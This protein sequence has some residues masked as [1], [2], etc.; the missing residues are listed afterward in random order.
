MIIE[1]EEYNS[2]INSMEHINTD[3]DNIIDAKK[4]AVIIYLD[5]FDFSNKVKNF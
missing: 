5:I 3:D 2:Y 1:K 4:E